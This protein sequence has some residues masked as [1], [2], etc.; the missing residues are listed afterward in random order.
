MRSDPGLSFEAPEGSLPGRHFVDGVS[1]SGKERNRLFAALQGAGYADLSG[2]SG[3]DDRADGRA[4]AVL[5]A[6]RDGWPDLAVVNAN[7]PGLQL[8]RNRIGEGRPPPAIGV[9]LEGA[10]RPGA[11]EGRSNRDGVGA[12][13]EVRAEGVWRV[14]ELRAGEGLAAQNSRLVGFGLGGAERADT[15]RV[16]WPSGAVSEVHDVPA[17][18]RIH[19]READPEPPRTAALAP[20]RPPARP[21]DREPVPEVALPGAADA[22]LRL[23][24]TFATWCEPCVA[25]LPELR[26]LREVFDGSELELLGVPVD[27]DDRGA[28]IERWVRRHAPPYRMLAE[29]PRER[30]EALEALLRERLGGDGIPASLLLDREGRVVHAR[31]GAPTVSELRR[32]LAARDGG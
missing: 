28:P 26:R 1:Q 5:D 12:R 10:A 3:A 27:P 2:L 7:A 24:T 25:E 14:R 8:F 11:S 30:V 29:L 23:V 19:L 4:F 15:L 17:G 22:R 18:T 21:P 20:A 16:R 32:L 9:T 6:D 31:F 13:I